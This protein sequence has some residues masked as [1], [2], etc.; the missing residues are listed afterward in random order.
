MIVVYAILALVG[1]LGTWFFNIAS[2]RSGEDYLAGWFATSAS[3]SAAVDVIV[4]AL[5]ACIFIVV[6]ARRLEMNLVLAALLVVLSFA[7]AI[8]FTFPAFLAW[9]T[10]HLNRTR[11][12]REHM[13][14]T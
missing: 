10:W 2:V 4:V 5:V 11:V 13:A 9:R 12:A 1:G 14:V 6:E 3:S 7:I 8:A